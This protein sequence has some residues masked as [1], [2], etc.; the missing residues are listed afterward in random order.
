MKLLI[1]IPICLFYFVTFSSAQDMIFKADKTEVKAKVMEI[2]DVSIKYKKWENQGGPTY[3][4]NKNDVFMIIYANGQRETIQATP[5]I[6]NKEAIITAAHPRASIPSPVNHTQKN[7]S[8]T[9]VDYKNA[10]INYNPSRI[11]YWLAEGPTT[12]GSS[13]EYRILKNIMNLGITWDFAAE[14]KITYNTYGIY[15]APYLAV[16]RLTGNFKN[17][18]KGLF[19]FGRIGYSATSI[20]YNGE[21]INN[22]GTGGV[23]FGFGADYMF[24]KGFG[25][26]GSFIKNG[27]GSFTLQTGLTLNF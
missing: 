4:I 12:I 5:V 13:S 26:N 6:E 9:L 10:R 18:D 25:I 7:A 24:T 22:G 8:D 17:Q 11:V 2:T 20:K 21:N 27:L 14:D 3:I 16:N 19:A 15:L 23:S 1:L